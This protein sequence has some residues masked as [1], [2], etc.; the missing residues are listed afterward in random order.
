MTA[1]EENLP[2]SHCGFRENTDM[3]FA[4]IQEKRCEQNKGL[5]VTF[6]DLTKTFDTVSRD[7]LCKTLEKMGFPPKFL[8]M[9]KQLHVNSYGQQNRDISSSFR[10]F[11]DV[12]QE[13]V[14]ALNLFT[15]FFSMMLQQAMDNLEEGVYIY[16]N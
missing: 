9:V 14:L 11:N 8:A 4:Q 15:I 13:C 1:A 6:L 2:E 16:F 5:N 3:L 10:I 12:Q 7:G